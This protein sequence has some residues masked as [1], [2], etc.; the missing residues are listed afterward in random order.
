MLLA[1]KHLLGN[2]LQS[3]NGQG[4][5]EA[6][7]DLSNSVLSENFRSHFRPK[8][9]ARRCPLDTHGDWKRAQELGMAALQSGN[10]QFSTACLRE[11]F[12]SYF[13]SLKRRQAGIWRY[14]RTCTCQMPHAKCQMHNSQCQMPNAKCEIPKKMRNLTAKRSNAECQMP[15]ANIAAASIIVKL[16]ARNFLHRHLTCLAYNHR[17]HSHYS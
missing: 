15:N 5:P 12:D 6:A 4:S 14:T 16:G 9:S 8:H 7:A 17:R 1:S 10:T 3:N 2:R 13:N 11:S